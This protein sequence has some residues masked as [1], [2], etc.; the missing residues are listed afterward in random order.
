MKQVCFLL[1]LKRDRIDDYLKAHQVWPE[2]LDV[3]REAGIRNYSLFLRE[4]GM[5]VGCLEAE[6]PEESLRKVAETEVSRRWEDGM[7]EYFED[8]GGGVE[9]RLRQYFHME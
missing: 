4:D 6:N 7:A 2:L 5:V 1:R 9:E 3:M 8:D